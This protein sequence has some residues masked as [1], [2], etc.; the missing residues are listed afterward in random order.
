MGRSDGRHEGRADGRHEGTFDGRP[1]GR[2]D[3]AL[4]GGRGRVGVLGLD[5][6]QAVAYAQLFNDPKAAGDLAGVRVVAAFPAA[7]SADI[8]WLRAVLSQIRRIRSEMNIAPGK[9]IPL[10]FANGS[11]LSLISAEETS[12]HGENLD[13]GVIDEAWAQRDDRL[14]Q[15]MRPAM[16][17]RDAQ[18]WIVSAA[19][20]EKSSY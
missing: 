10:L 7:A 13:L 11:M 12:G 1:E 20:N 15:A 19:G 18:L 17:T 3:G 8:E 5:N 16:M 14:E 4:D 6:Y 9:A 2:P